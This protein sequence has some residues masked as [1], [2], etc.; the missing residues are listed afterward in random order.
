[1][2]PSIA[3]HNDEI[4]ALCRKH[5]ILRLEIFGSAARG[6][7]FDE[8][9]S[10]V[11]LIARFD[12]KNRKQTFVEYQDFVD[13]LEKLVG[14]RIDLSEDVPIKNPFLKDSINK[15]RELLYEA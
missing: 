4:V 11:D 5:G 9:K 2:H 13:D 15:S 7:D 12:Y 6:T 8:I 10:D 1:M 3:K 14:R